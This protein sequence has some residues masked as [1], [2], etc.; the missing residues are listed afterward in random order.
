[1]SLFTPAATAENPGDDFL[2]IFL[3]ASIL[4]EYR[5]F[6]NTEY[7]SPRKCKIQRK[8]TEFQSLAPLEK[9]IDVILTEIN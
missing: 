5:Y 4:M 1:M 7:K 6:Y 9:F 3:F 8:F 2:K